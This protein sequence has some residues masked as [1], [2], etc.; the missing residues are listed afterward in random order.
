[1][2]R[3]LKAVFVYSVP[4]NDPKIWSPEAAEEVLTEDDVDTADE[5]DVDAAF[6]DEE[7]DEDMS[8]SSRASTSEDA[9]VAFAGSTSSTS[10]EEDAVST[11]SELEEAAA[12]DDSFV[13]V[14]AASENVRVPIRS[15]EINRSFFLILSS[16]AIRKRTAYSVCNLFAYRILYFPD[17]SIGPFQSI[18]QS[19]S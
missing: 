7:A 11:T 6:V 14:Q 1:M 15:I 10:T 4:E 12:E 3:K 2:N 16:C 13:P 9:T 8:S 5:E 19:N 17:A 18:H